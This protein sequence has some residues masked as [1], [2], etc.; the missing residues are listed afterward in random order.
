MLY[1]YACCIGLGLDFDYA[2]VTFEYALIL[3]IPLQF[4]LYVVVEGEPLPLSKPSAACTRFSSSTVHYFSVSQPG[5]RVPLVVR[6]EIS[7]GP[8]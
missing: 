8:R 6:V 5:V 1:I 7:R 3:T 2:T 4:C